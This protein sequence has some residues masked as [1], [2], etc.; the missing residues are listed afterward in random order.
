MPLKPG[1]IAPDFTTP[2]QNN[3]LVTLSSFRGQWV[4]LYFYPEDDTPGCT[5]EACGIRDSFAEFQGKI[6]VLGVS[7]DS[8]ESHQKFQQKYSLPFLLLSDQNKSVSTL[9]D[10]NGLLFSKRISYLIDPTG[11]IVKVYPKVNVSTHA[12]TILRDF[13]KLTQK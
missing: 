13:A 4:L 11:H 1:I 10:T 9:Y 2:D 7:H 6:T 3:S 5:K 12:K 8:V